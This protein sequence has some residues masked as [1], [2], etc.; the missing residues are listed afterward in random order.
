MITTQCRVGERINEVLFLEVWS[1]IISDSTGK[2][3]DS[4]GGSFVHNCI[5]VCV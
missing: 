3:K 2:D 4:G 1:N 5:K